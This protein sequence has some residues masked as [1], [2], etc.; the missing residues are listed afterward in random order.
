METCRFT[1]CKVAKRL[2]LKDRS[3]CP[4]YLEN[5]FVTTKGEKVTVH[6]CAPVRSM[7]MMQ[8]LHNQ[9]IGLQKVSEQQRNRV[10]LVLNLVNDVFIAQKAKLDAT[11]KAI[12]I[13]GEIID[14]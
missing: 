4:N 10:D 1:T 14:A 3:E 5:I 13:E 8:D 2:K 11:D 6:D 9:I 7:L 12:D